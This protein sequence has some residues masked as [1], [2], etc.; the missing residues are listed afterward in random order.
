LTARAGKTTTS[1][2]VYPEREDSRFWAYAVVFL[3]RSFLFVSGQLEWTDL[4]VP[5]RMAPIFPDSYPASFLRTVCSF[6]IHFLCLGFSQCFFFPHFRLRV[7]HL[8]GLEVFYCS[9]RARA[10]YEVPFLPDVR[11]NFSCFFLPFFRT[12]TFDR[13]TSFCPLN[14]THEKNDQ[15]PKPEIHNTMPDAL[16]IP[17]RFSF[18]HVG[19]YAEMADSNLQGP[20][21]F[22]VFIE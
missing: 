11:S 2:L 6:V 16:P 19:R 22:L 12:S 14:P 9:K 8:V 15:V 4:L 7:N 20:I 3:R 5:R 10:A 21:S 18:N 13:S 17:S 1:D